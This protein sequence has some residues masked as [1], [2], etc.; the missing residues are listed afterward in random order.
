MGREPKKLTNCRICG[1]AEL[2]AILDLGIQA[3]TGIFPKSVDAS[4]TSGPLILVKCTAEQGCGLLQ[5]A[6]SYDLEEMYGENYG[7]RSGLNAS[8]VAHLRAKVDRIKSYGVIDDGAIILDIGSNDGTTLGLYGLENVRLVGI[9]PTAAKFRQYYQDGV[10]VIAD[11]FSADRFREAFGEQKARVITSFS[12]FYDM[13]DPTGFMRE[14][15]EILDETKGIWVCEQSYMPLMLE[16]NSYDTACHEHLEYYALAQIV[17]MARHAGLEIVD[18]ELN[19]V[20]GGSFSFVAQRVGGGLAR[21]AA[22]DELLAREQALRLDDLGIYRK[23]A[24]DVVRLRDEFVAFLHKAKAEGKRVAALGASTKGNVL[25]QYCNVTRDLI[26]AVG[27]VNP[28]KFG[29][30]TPGTNLPI[31]DETELLASKPDYLV[32]LPWHFRGFFESQPRYAGL[33]LVFPLPELSVG[34]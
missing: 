8:M 17:W 6:H 21:T 5:L 7:Y 9:D 1:G 23:F 33:S 13:E 11:F 31:I 12:M 19:A 10:V 24:A 26:E 25:L 29:A 18:V 22:V 28:D 14:V 15:S 2:T 16:T 30:F 3:L 4:I 27:E 32:V 34:K 20:N